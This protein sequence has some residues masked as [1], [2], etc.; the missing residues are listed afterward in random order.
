[1]NTIININKIESL[2]EDSTTLKKLKFNVRVGNIVWNQC[3]DILTD[4]EKYTRLI[5]SSDIVEHNLSITEYK[6]IK[7][8]NYI[9]SDG[10]KNPIIVVNRGYGTGKYNFNYCIVDIDEEYLI[11][12]HLII[13]EYRDKSD[14]DKL[15]KEYDK[16]KKSF[17]NEKTKHFIE[18]Y[19]CNSAMNCTELH[20]VLPIYV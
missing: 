13:I 19:C 14:V 17:E 4:D 16:I 20:T 2:Y 1:M 3:K 12:N 15:L 7:K 9:K 6:N 11:E 10:I 8:K 18:L 5:Y